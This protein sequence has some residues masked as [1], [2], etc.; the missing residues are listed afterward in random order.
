MCTEVSIP[1]AGSLAEAEARGRQSLGRE[2]PIFQI[3]ED[4]VKGVGELAVVEMLHK[5]VPEELGITFG[6]NSQIEPTDFV[7]GYTTRGVSSGPHLH[8]GLQGLTVHRE[9]AGDAEIEAAFS[10]KFDPGPA[11]ITLE[12]GEEYVPR[13]EDNDT[14]ISELKGLSGPIYKGTTVPGR[15][16]VFSETTYARP[17]KGTLSIGEGRRGKKIL[18]GVVHNFRRQGQEEGNWLALISFGFQRDMNKKRVRY[19]DQPSVANPNVIAVF[20]S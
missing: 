18:E 11:I 20:V 1:I 8:Y 16:T 4:V 12:D 19:R 9:I 17:A 2:L 3:G 15:I 10:G 14:R 13:L 6:Y 7:Q 5:I